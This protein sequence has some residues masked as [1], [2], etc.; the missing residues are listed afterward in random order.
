MTLGFIKI[1]MLLC[2]NTLPDLEN[3]IVWAEAFSD[4]ESASVEIAAQSYWGLE[5]G[6]S[7]VGNKLSSPC[8]PA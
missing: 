8:Q 3:D 2:A 1:K 5:D 7:G 6:F 4:P